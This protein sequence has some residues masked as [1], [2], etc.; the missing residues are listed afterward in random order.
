MLVEVSSH[1]L[2]VYVQQCATVSLSQSEEVS[3]MHDF[4]P[5]EMKKSA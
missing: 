1:Q 5:T 4:F 3:M 2:L